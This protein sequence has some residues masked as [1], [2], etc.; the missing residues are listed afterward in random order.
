MYPK[1]PNKT[2][3]ITGRKALGQTVSLKF[4]TSLSTYC[5]YEFNHPQPNLQYAAVHIFWVRRNKGLLQTH[6]QLKTP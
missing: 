1:L 2:K 6:G 3:N 4:R 5:S